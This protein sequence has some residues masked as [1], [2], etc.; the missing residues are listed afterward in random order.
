MPT[1]PRKSR[2]NAPKRW[3]DH[4]DAAKKRWRIAFGDHPYAHPVNG[5]LD[6]VA[7]LTG[8]DLLAATDV[9]RLLQVLLGL[10]E[11]EYRHHRL[12]VGADGK[13]SRVRDYAGIHARAS[14]Y[15][16][17]ALVA[18]VELLT[19]APT[20]VVLSRAPRLAKKPPPTWMRPKQKASL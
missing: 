19:Q 15:G 20:K 9:H 3:P 18:V 2:P 5:T 1:K 12:L 14:G 4:A 16:Q 17:Q 13:Q 6:S 7:A 11:P 8:E 10:P